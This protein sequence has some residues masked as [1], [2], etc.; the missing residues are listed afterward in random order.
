MDGY[1]I[2][3]ES[4]DHRQ[5]IGI[6]GGTFNPIHNGHLLI[7]ENAL[8]QY[9]LD[10]IYFIPTGLSPH[11]GRQEIIPAG[12]RYEM[13]ERAISGNPGFAVSSIE[14]DSTETS[15][16]YHTLE[17]LTA[18]YPNKQFYFIMGGDSLRDFPGWKNPRRICE[19]CHLLAAVR[20][21]MDMDML[22]SQANKIKQI[23]QGDVDL[24]NTPNFS[25]SSHEIR[26]RIRNHDSIRYLVPEEVRIYIK[27]NQLY[28]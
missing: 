17:K 19:L 25:V 8:C 10:K 15:Y 22:Y 7:A 3:T 12:F 28:Q 21:D 24:L 1:Q 13:I 20:N 27:E 16:T 23:F 6:M 14:I 5:K 9:H 4:F 11:K 18:L 26:E 2:D